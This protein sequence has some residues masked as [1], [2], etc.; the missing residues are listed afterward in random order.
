M[1]GA[2]V[3]EIIAQVRRAITE[4]NKLQGRNSRLLIEKKKKELD[5]A[6]SSRLN[7]TA[8]IQKITSEQSTAYNEEEA[9][10]KQRS[11]LL[12]LSLGDRNTSLFHAA[13]KGRKRANSFS[14]IENA[15]GVEVHKEEDIVKSI[16]AYFQELFTSSDRVGNRRETVE[17]ALR[18]VITDE[19][20]ALLSAIPSALEI[21]EAIF[22]INAEKAPGPDGFS[23]RFFQS[24]W[25]DIGEEIVD[26]I[27]AFF[28]SGK[29]PEGINHTHVRLIPKIQSPQ[30]V[31][32]YRPIALC[33]VYYKTISKI[34]TKRL[35]PLLGSLISENQSA[36]VP[37]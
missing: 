28:I 32:D 29:P 27:Q 25:L 30:R 14:V 19:E 7:D 33:N 20:N 13:T 9:Y 10:W 17:Y 37:G 36:F 11:R 4:W 34:L 24:N 31:S 1:A 23:A 8:L 3:S 2:P 21:K 6:L 12:W 15:A 18:P 22:D 5:A 35:Q 26:K 16:V